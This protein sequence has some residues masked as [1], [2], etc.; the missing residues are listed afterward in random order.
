MPLL[1]L[2][3]AY[4]RDLTLWFGQKLLDSEANIDFSGRGRANDDAQIVDGANDAL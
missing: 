2:V 1:K 3:H 4:L